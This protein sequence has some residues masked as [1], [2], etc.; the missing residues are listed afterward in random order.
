QC[1]PYQTLKIKISGVPKKYWTEDV[2]LA[3]SAYGTVEKIEMEKASP[4]NGAFVIFQLPLS[5]DFQSIAHLQIGDKLVNWKKINAPLRLKTIQGALEPAERYC[6]SNTI[7][8]NTLDFGMQK[9]SLSMVS[10]F[11]VQAKW[12]VQLTLSLGRKELDIRFPLKVNDETRNF[13]FRL[14]ISLLSHIYQ[15]ESAGQTSLI[16]PFDHIPQFYQQMVEGDRLLHGRKYTSFSDNDMK[17]ADWNTWYRETDI[18]EGAFRKHLQDLPVMNHKDAA[19]ID[20]GRWTTYRL[21]FDDATLAK[22]QFNEFSTILADCGVLIEPVDQYSVQARSPSAVW[23]LLHD[24][25]S[26]T[27]PH[28]DSHEDQPSLFTHL[29]ADQVHLSFPVRYQ[30]EACLSNGFLKEHNITRM[31]LEKLHG[32]DPSQATS[33]LEKVANKKFVHHDPMEIFNM[34]VSSRLRRRSMPNYCVLQ[35]SVVITPTTMHVNTP[36]METSN[37]ITR[38]HSIIADR[39]IRVKFSDEKTEGPLRT[40]PNDRAEATFERVRRA[41][42]NGIVVAGRYYEFLAFGNSQFRENGAYFYAPTSLRSADD[43]RSSLGNFDH[44]RSVAK[45]GARL[46]QAFS[47][48][49]AIATSAKIVN[50]NDV[51]RNGHVF[52]DGVGK[53]SSFIASMA[54]QDLGLSNAFND[55]P[56]LYQFRLGGYKGVLAID[57]TLKGSEIHIRPS[58]QKFEAH[59]TRLEIIR[60]SSLSTPFFNRQIIMVLSTLGVRDEIII[61]KQQQMVDD[62]ARAMFVEEVAIDRLQRHIDQ[63]ETTLTMAR[64]VLDGF[65]CDP[66]VKSLLKLWR[67][68]AIKH[69]KERARIAI[70][71]GAFVLGCVDE[72]AILKGHFDHAQPPPSAARDEKLASLPEIF[73]QIDDTSSGKKGHYKVIKGVC[74]LARNPSL[75]PGD[76]R[77][78]RAVDVPELHHHK[79]VVVFPQTGDRDLASMCSGGDLDGDDYMVLWDKDLIP[80]IINVEPMDFTPEK[81]PEVDRPVSVADITE[82]FVTYMKNNSLGQIAH[83]HLAQADY[84]GGVGHETCLELAKLHSQAVD[85]NKSGI[86]AVLTNDLR[87]CKWPHF[88]EKKYVPD[89][90]IYKSGKI[91]GQL[92]DR[93]ELVAFAAQ[94]ENPFDQRVLQ[95]FDLDAEILQQ[96]AEIKLLYD[97]SLR[98]LMAKHG[99][100][101]EFE[102]WSVFVLEHNHETNKYKFVEDFGRTICALKT[103]FRDMCRAEAGA[104]PGAGVGERVDF[105]PFAA[106]MYMVTAKE[107]EAA[108]EECRTVTVVDGQEKALREMTPA[109]MPLISFPWLFPDDLGKIA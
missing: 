56:S 10:M 8:A 45:Y 14:P 20:I 100:E 38:Q 94:Y 46:G 5:V 25:I 108:L 58:Q 59:S 61:K 39:F 104:G 2:H 18:V 57:P 6:E 86:P 78:V 80:E 71:D 37:R 84:L 97:E 4:N 62:Y 101:T 67:A 105:G 47:T 19:M 74:I 50:I 7:F 26:E 77:V 44:I 76:V 35:Q 28:L 90:K 70:D 21:S 81:P 65:M 93:V 49:R 89:D 102:A 107:V 87:P 106:A 40:M 103:H 60:S 96:A 32:L 12:K 48:T 15:V 92:Y 68:H 23:K 53:L 99:I 9:S 30:L 66:F 51:E 63:N 91:L 33:L 109:Q 85:Y 83:A 1:W 29:L 73:I 64:M 72:T 79:N 54:A 43:I 31:F 36:V 3:M 16:I 75:H 27:H 24:E 55:P 11:T 98:R 95:A 42:K 88:M 82:F 69:L 52:S 22:N 41:M 13:R 17:W 34:E